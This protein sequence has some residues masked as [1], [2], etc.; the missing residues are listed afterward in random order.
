METQLV[1]YCV[2]C[3]R[4]GLGETPAEWHHVRERR[5]GKR[6]DLGFWVCPRHHR[7]GP[8]AIHVMGKKR[9]EKKFGA[10]ESYLTNS[11]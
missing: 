10:E 2:V 5:L 8:D 6:G 7:I 4:L 11:L 3:K 9:W 1:H